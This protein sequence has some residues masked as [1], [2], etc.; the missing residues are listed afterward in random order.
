MTFFLLGGN[1][2]SFWFLAGYLWGW[3]WVK[4]VLW[5]FPYRET[6]LDL[7][8][9]LF[10]L[11]YVVLSL[12]GGDVGGGSQRLLCV[13][14]TSVLVVLWLLLDCDNSQIPRFMHYSSRS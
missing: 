2:E 14:P 11:Y 1:F 3:G 12:F 5:G 6:T 10:L 7:S 9:A 8:I 4:K 13:N